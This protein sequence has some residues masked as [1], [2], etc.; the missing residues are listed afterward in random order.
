MQKTHVSLVD[1]DAGGAV[2]AGLR[3]LLAEVLLGLA[4]LSLEMEGRNSLLM[5]CPKLSKKQELGNEIAA[6]FSPEN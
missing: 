5:Q 4:V 6:I 3:E 1:G 2:P